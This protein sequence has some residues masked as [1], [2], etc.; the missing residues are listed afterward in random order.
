MKLFLIRHGQSTAN[1]KG[2]L[3]SNRND[4][5]SKKGVIQSKELKEKIISLNLN[6]IKVYSSPWSRAKETAEILFPNEEIIF[7]EELA[8]TNPGDFGNWLEKDFFEKF[9]DFSK[10]IENKYENGESHYDM[11]K[12]VVEILNYILDKEDRNSDTSIIIIYHGGPISISLQY[13]LNIEI[14]NNYPSFTVPNASISILNWREDFN[15]FVV[16]QIGI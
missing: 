9:S 15:R 2:L 16:E 8:E 14:K 7:H 5:L 12:R 4:S 10:N 3:I 13:L 1:E 6:K 11:S